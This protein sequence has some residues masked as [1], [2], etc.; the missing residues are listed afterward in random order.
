MSFPN[1]TSTSATLAPWGSVATP[2]GAACTTAPP[3]R[4]RGAGPSLL[5]RASLPI[6]D[7]SAKH[8]VL[9]PLPLPGVLRRRFVGEWIDPAV[10]SAIVADAHA[11]LEGR[12]EAPADSLECPGPV[13]FDG[14]GRIKSLRTRLLTPELVGRLEAAIISPLS[15]TRSDAPREAPRTP[16]SILVAAMH[17]L[18]CDAAPEATGLMTDAR[19]LFLSAS[20]S[21]NGVLRLV[22]D[23][24]HSLRNEQLHGKFQEFA[25]ELRQDVSTPQLVDSL[26]GRTFESLLAEDLV[27]NPPEG[28]LTAARR[29]GE[30]LVGILE[31]LEKRAKNGLMIYIAK[32]MRHWVRHDL[33]QSSQW[34]KGPRPWHALCPRFKEFTG[35][36]SMSTLRPCLV[37]V[38]SGVEAVLVPL[39]ATSAAR[40]LSLQSPGPIPSWLARANA[41]YSAK[42]RPQKPTEMSMLVQVEGQLLA[43]EPGNWLHYQPKVTH[44]NTLR[45]IGKDHAHDRVVAPDAASSRAPSGFTK[46]T[47]LKGQT[48]VN[49]PSGQT[50]LSEWLAQHLA[51]QEPDFPLG[52]HR[53]NTMMALVFDGGHS[54]EEVLYTLKFAEE[55]DQPLASWL[56]KWLCCSTDE[57][58]SG[59]EAIPFLLETSADQQALRERLDKA[60]DQTLDYHAKH[61]AR[62]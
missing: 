33:T 3:L 42:V 35:R 23:C 2:S 28:I 49:G 50:W 62:E 54:T 17:L 52:F 37:E 27:R 9:A 12:G 61:I 32:E 29:L 4:P 51:Q 34:D 36:Q 30:G 22:G 15:Q 46:N 25:R 13:V 11:E 24:S 45:P 58:T 5:P 53:L 8:A 38:T 57:P 41:T 14:N 31:G 20:F 7:S 1:D 26:Y 47:L 55:L 60:L 44:F 10:A 39:L 6:S 18:R 56:C 48:V 19:K 43:R 59:Y 21:R 16:R 40:G